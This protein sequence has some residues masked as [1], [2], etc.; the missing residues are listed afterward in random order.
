VKQVRA[1]CEPAHLFSCRLEISGEEGAS[2]A[3]ENR[4]DSTLAPEKHPTGPK[5]RAHFA[6]FSARLKSCP[7]TKLAFETGWAS[8]SAACEVVPRF[9]YSILRGI[10]L[11][12]RLRTAGLY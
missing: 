12:A 11:P 5:G 10:S 3:T 8:F 9:A 2:K 6:A 4:L 1:A 7:D